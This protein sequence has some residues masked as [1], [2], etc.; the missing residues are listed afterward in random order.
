[1][2]YGTGRWNVLHWVTTKVAGNSHLTLQLA[3]THFQRACA[4]KLLLLLLLL[5]QQRRLLI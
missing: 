2:Y 5:L 4:S 1:M 3:C